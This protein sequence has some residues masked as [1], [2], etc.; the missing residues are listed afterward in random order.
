ME[1]EITGAV[2][3]TWR[4]DQRILLTMPGE[5]LV[6]DIRAYNAGDINQNATGR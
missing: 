2:F 3:Q 4:T 1:P 6:F 5:D